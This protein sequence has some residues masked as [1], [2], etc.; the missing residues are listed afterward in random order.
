MKGIPIR[1]TIGPKDIEKDQLEL[2]RKILKKKYLLNKS[3]VLNE[4]ENLKR[5]M[6]IY[7]KEPKNFLKKTLQRL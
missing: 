3:F 5:F 2:A 6:L 1:I 7:L 4:V